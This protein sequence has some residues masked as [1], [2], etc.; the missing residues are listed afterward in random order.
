MNTPAIVFGSAGLE[1]TTEQRRP[2]PHAD[3]AAATTCSTIVLIGA[4]TVVGDR[5]R[6]DV[7]VKGGVKMYRSPE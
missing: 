1:F 7:F 5:H 3:N 6:Q 2:F 4:G